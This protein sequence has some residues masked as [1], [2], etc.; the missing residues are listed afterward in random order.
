MRASFGDGGADFFFG[1]LGVLLVFVEFCLG[2]G[3]FLVGFE[4]VLLVFFLFFEDGGAGERLGRSCAAN[5][6][7][8]GFHDAVSQSGDLIV[9]QGFGFGGGMRQLERR[10]F[11]ARRIIAVRAQRGVVGYADIFFGADGSS[12]G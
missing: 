7:L 3:I 4:F 8:L 5:F 10:G 1:V 6:F 2:C 12:F 9:V 11:M